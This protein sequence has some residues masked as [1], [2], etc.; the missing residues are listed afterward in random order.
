M[1]ISFLYNVYKLL[2][3]LTTIL[4]SLSTAVRPDT[5][6]VCIR[7]NDISYD[8]GNIA[9]H[10]GV[11]SGIRQGLYKDCGRNNNEKLDAVL[12]EW[13]QSQCSDVTW[14]KLVDALGKAG[15]QKTADEVKQYLINDPEA[16]RKYNCTIGNCIINCKSSQS[17]TR[18][19]LCS[20]IFQLK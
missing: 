3:H 11:P 13:D 1:R 7:L 14:D 10:L 4:V 19:I 5:N 8:W 17:C 18:N 20:N 9:Q 16:K 12:N 2:S 6:D 15:H